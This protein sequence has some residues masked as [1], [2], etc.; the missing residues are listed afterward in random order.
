MPVDWDAVAGQAAQAVAGIIGNTV[1]G[2]SAGAQAQVTALV[3]IGQQIEQNRGSMQQAEY[4][5][6]KLM[7][8]RA[9]KG[10]L[11]TYEAIAADVA[12]QA[13]A[14]AWGVLVTALKGAYP[15]LGVL[16]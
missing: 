15:T 5:S 8:Q 2:L 10:V 7:Q 6:L 16:L 13:A 4:D 12:Q 11:Q 3:Q 14:A 9:L 1:Q